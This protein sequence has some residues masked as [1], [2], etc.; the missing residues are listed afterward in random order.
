M[1]E[2]EEEKK[3]L[4][5]EKLRQ[6]K[7]NQKNISITQSEQISNYLNQNKNNKE[8]SDKRTIKDSELEHEELIINESNKNRI[9]NYNKDLLNNKNNYIIGNNNHIN[10]YK[11]IYD[12]EVTNKI[13]YELEKDLLIKQKQN[14]THKLMTGK[15]SSLENSEVNIN[16]TKDKKRGKLTLSDLDNEQN[17]KL[18]EIE[19]I[20]KGGITDTKLNQLKIKYRDNKKVLELINIYKEK[21]ST[22][23]NNDNNSNISSISNSNSLMNN[24]KYNT[25]NNIKS[26]KIKYSQYEQ[27]PGRREFT[28]EEIIQNKINIFKNKIYCPFFDKIK[29][30]KENERKR[31]ELLKQI[32]DP[33]VR[34]SVEAK[35]AI[36]RGRVDMELTNEKEKINKAIKNY[37]KY[38]MQSE[39][40]SRVNANT[41]I[42]FE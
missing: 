7:E 34:E 23:E 3:K 18:T 17:E 42:F 38:L 25:T 41:N 8:N 22:I 30:E 26:K 29:K 39:N 11:K 28:R 16:K 20:L 10:N 14:Y 31:L 40:L 24:T 13:K 2:I 15:N 21:K 4:E 19:N 5:E 37:E 35:F 32:T 6:E 33:I 27:I 1:K 36:E 12:K 9:I